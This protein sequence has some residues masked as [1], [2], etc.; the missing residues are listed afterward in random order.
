VLTKTQLLGFNAE[1]YRPIIEKWGQAANSVSS[2]SSTISGAA[3]QIYDW[4]GPAADQA[5][6]TMGDLVAVVVNAPQLFNEAQDTLGA[7]VATVY[8]QQEILTGAL[9]KARSLNCAVDEDGT[10]TAPP[11]PSPAPPESCPMDPH[12]AA[13]W[14]QEQQAYYRIPEVKTW[15]AATRQAP[16][17][18]STIHDALQLAS[19]A[20]SRAARD[21]QAGIQGGSDVQKIVAGQDRTGSYLGNLY[22][23]TQKLV[24]GHQWMQQYVHQVA[25]LLP[26]AAD[27]DSAAVAELDQLAPLTWNEDFGASLMNQLGAAGLEHLPIEM[28]EKLQEIANG[29]GDPSRVPGLVARDHAILSFLG[30]SL[31]S[32][33]N[34]PD[35]SP[36]FVQALTNDDTAQYDDTAQIDDA[37]H[38]EHGPAGLWA[39]GQILGASSKD[40]Q[41]GSQFLTTVG[42]AIINFDGQHATTHHY[43]DAPY[44]YPGPFAYPYATNASPWANN[45]NL[46]AGSQPSGPTFF[47]VTDS[48]G[49]PIYGL[50]HAAADSPAAA[51]ALF[52]S[53]ANLHTVLTDLPW[54][55]DHASSL[56]SAL[57]A[58]GTGP[59]ALRANLTSSIVNILAGQYGNHAGY[60]AQMSG[61]NTHIASILA[62][63][64]DI[65]AM[66]QAIGSDIQEP[67]GTSIPTGADGI[68][69]SF[70]TSDLA[71]VL[72]FIGQTPSAYSTLLHAQAQYMANQLNQAVAAAQAQ[73]G[74]IHNPANNSMI[75]QDLSQGMATLGSWGC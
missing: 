68:G 71:L 9:K 43:I 8:Q 27:G 41:Y 13:S 12:L 58:A 36:G 19:A 45:M 75:A 32:A 28:G 31:A 39:L 18:Q 38:R 40:A 46:S 69:P 47:G 70:Q 52:H 57:Q 30:N 72:G 50:M 61:L 6:T 44:D 53:A 24:D 73:P 74:G 26:K 11:Q 17:L 16:G 5:L 65:A 25:A 14:A 29:Q 54:N 62:Q 49:D 59:G 20:D 48:G 67:S 10:V 63:P 23:D 34:S 15:Q 21:L 1:N 2:A 37:P 66:N 35:L 42:T 56:G 55:Y 33:S 51:L 22:A 64:Q 3:D 4:T 7:F 60:A